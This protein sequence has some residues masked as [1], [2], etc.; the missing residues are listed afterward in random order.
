MKI[1]RFIAAALPLILPGALAQENTGGWRIATPGWVYQFPRD[2]GAHRDFKTEWWYFTGELNAADG[3]EFGYELTWF[4]EGV[5]PARPPG[6]SRFV[7]G[8]FKFAHFAISDV[9][10]GKFFFAQ[11]IA[12]GAYGE[13]GNGNGQPGPL[14]WIDD[15]KLT[16]EP[17]GNWH[18][19]AAHEGRA[20]DLR[21]TP[22]K[23]PVIEGESGISRKS[24]GAGRAGYASCYYS[25]TRMRTAGE[26]TLPG[27]AP[28]NVTGESWFD[29]E[30][31]TNSLAPDEAGWDWFSLQFSD[32][33]ELMLYRMRLKNGLADPASSGTYIRR[34]GTP[35][36]LKSDDFHLIPLEW[37]KSPVTDGN[38][39]IRWRIVIPRLGLSLEA[40]APIEDQELAFPSLVYW[41]GLIDASGT[42]AGTAVTGHG[43]LELTGYGNLAPGTGE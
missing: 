5:I 25:F 7:V 15:W 11:K 43:Y 23:G 3:R 31:A 28:I 42:S 27:A 9:Q 19:S 24:T 18:I 37:W 6:L 8:D 30:W 17:S 13:A 20:V 4:R 22:L 1:A 29:H 39:P 33:T 14:A 41:E 12:R 32:G 21:L 10:A 2:H 16:I 40:T 34:D 26:L 38:Y 35:I 36:Y